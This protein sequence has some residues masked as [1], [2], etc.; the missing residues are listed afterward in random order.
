MGMLDGTG[1]FGDHAGAGIH[2][3]ISDRTAVRVAVDYQGTIS[4]D[5]T[6]RIAVGLSRTF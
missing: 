2:F 4:D 5:H 1:D 3:A 6:F